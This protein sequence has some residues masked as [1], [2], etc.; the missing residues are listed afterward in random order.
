L[1]VTD[2]PNASAY[3]EVISTLETAERQ[4]QRLAAR[5]TVYLQFAGGAR[6]RAQELAERLS[7]DDFIM[8]GEERHAGAA[9]KR[10]IR[11]YYDEDVPSAE[12][13]ADA[14]HQALIGMGYPGE[15]PV[16]LTDLTGYRGQKPKQGILELWVE[17]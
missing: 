13:L 7:A 14:T 2:Q 15:P 17:L 8:P 1:K 11:Y 16:K 5:P 9:G 3:G 12:R 10:E 6:G 4:A